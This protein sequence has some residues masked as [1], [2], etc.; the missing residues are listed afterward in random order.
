[1]FQASKHGKDS[2]FTSQ[3]SASELSSFVETAKKE[4]GCDEI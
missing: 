1:M 2:N 3:I 4:K